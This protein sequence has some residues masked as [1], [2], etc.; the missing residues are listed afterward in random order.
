MSFLPVYFLFSPRLPGGVHPRLPGGFVFYLPGGLPPTK[1][2]C[3]IIPGVG[4]A[5]A[6]SSIA[7]AEVP[8]M[9]GLLLNVH[10]TKTAKIYKKGT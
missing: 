3:Q 2:L 6:A 10:K 4:V 8:C 5:D 1:W 7:A 9:R